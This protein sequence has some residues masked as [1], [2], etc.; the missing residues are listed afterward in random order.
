MKFDKIFLIDVLH[1]GLAYKEFNSAVPL[2]AMEACIGGW[3]VGE[4]V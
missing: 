4:E 1:S 3:G 2:H